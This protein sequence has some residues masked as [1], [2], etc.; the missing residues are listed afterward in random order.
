LDAVI[1]YVII[2]LMG[3]CLGMIGAGGSILAV[4]VLVYLFRVDPTLATA[5]ASIIVGVTAATASVRSL[6]TKSIDLRSAFWFGVPC[7]IGTYV[8]RFCLVRVIPKVII[9]LANFTLTRDGFVML[10]F[11]G[12]MLAAG[13]SMLSARNYEPGMPG[14]YANYGTLLLMGLLVGVVTGVVGAGGG[15][16]I[17]PSLVIVAGLNMPLAVGTSLTIIAFKSIVS[18]IGDFSSGL[19]V[20]LFLIVSLLCVA[21]PSVMVGR[22]LNG[23]VKTP[24]LKTGFGLVICVVGGLMGIH[25]LVQILRA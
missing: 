13:F 16:L 20:N 1:G 17:L 4:P 8:A 18:A 24:A 11:S 25:Q 5:Y 9:T 22:W 14:Q 21:I 3:L 23:H 6:Q 12:T 7:I 2:S 15:F 19:D 10:L